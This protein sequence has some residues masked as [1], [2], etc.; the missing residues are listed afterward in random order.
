MSGIARVWSSLVTMA[1][2]AST[3]SAGTPACSERRGHHPRA[4]ELAHGG[5]D[6]ERARRDFAQHRKRADDCHEL[7]ELRPTMLRGQTSLG[8]RRQ[9]LS[10]GK[11]PIDEA[12]PRCE[13]ASSWRPAP[14][15]AAMRE[16]RVGDAAHRRHDDGRASPS[17][18]RVRARSRSRRRM[19]SGSATDVPPNF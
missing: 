8:R 7:V 6:I 5:Y 17:R 19:A 9:L 15:P 3:H 13:S 14:A 11:V 2:R 12:A 1:R 18:A 16:Q 10:G 4:E